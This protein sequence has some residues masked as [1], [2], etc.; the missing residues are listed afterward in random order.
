M[1]TLTE[2]TSYVLGT[3]SDEIGASA[4]V[5]NIG[6]QKSG[7]QTGFFIH[8]KQPYTLWLKEGAV[9]SQHQSFSSSDLQESAAYAWGSSTAAYVQT[10]ESTH[11]VFVYPRTGS[12][13][14][15]GDTSDSSKEADTLVQGSVTT[16]LNV[17]TSQV[18]PSSGQFK[19]SNWMGQAPGFQAG[20]ME[21]GGV[22]AY[23]EA[24]QLTFHKEDADGVDRSAFLDQYLNAKSGQIKTILDANSGHHNV[25]QIVGASI[26]SNGNYKFDVYNVS[27]DDIAVTTGST[28]VYF[29][30]VGAEGAQGP[31]GPAG[32]DGAEGPQGPQGPAGANGTSGDMGGTMTSHIIPDTNAAY[33]LGNAEY[34]IRHLFLSDNSLWVGD[35]H[36]ISVD[37][38]GVVGFRKRKNTIMPSYLAS[39]GVEESEVLA[40]FGV[41]SIDDITPHQW[42]EFSQIRLGNPN[43]GIEDIFLS[44]DFEAQQGTTL[45]APTVDGALEVTSTDIDETAFK[46]S[47]PGQDNMFCVDAKSSYDDKARI[48]VKTTNDF[49]ASDVPYLGYQRGLFHIEREADE[50]QPA[51]SVWTHGGAA[52]D[53]SGINLLS[54]ST[55][56]NQGSYI[57]LL[58]NDG[59]FPSGY[60][61]EA[62]VLGRV[63][64]GGY[65]NNQHR[66]SAFVE[67]KATENWS[68]GNRLGSKLVFKTCEKGGNAIGEHLTVSSAGVFVHAPDSAP[69]TTDMNNSTTAMHLDEAQ[70]KLTFTVKYSDG[71][72]KTG[73]VDLS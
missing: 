48:T 69:D 62:K 25:F 63:A 15:D 56:E 47:V 55:Q 72:V 36:K 40:H 65:T 3:D 60:V 58:S 34:K 2:N 51:I 4:P 5:G 35:G 42:L 23:G 68:Y 20:N 37:D 6:F 53:V 67:A 29:V 10:A 33:D 9:W 28:T 46:V 39:E 43:L 11:Q 18:V 17:T 49:D 61:P 52:T 32:A 44:A 38:S 27:H 13:L 19:W 31:A 16:P 50:V 71:T 7:S 66:Q 14:V 21:Y 8:S 1:S 45:N 26:D 30:L 41:A 64:F 57:N 24:T 12:L 22:A 54:W 70:N 73:T 59:A